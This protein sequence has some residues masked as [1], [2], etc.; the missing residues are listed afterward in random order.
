MKVGDMVSIKMM[1]RYMRSKC[2]G[3]EYIDA[4]K[5]PRCGEIV[6][7]LGNGQL[8]VL[9]GTKSYLLYDYEVE[10]KGAMAERLK[11]KDMLEAKLHEL[12]DADSTRIKELLDEGKWPYIIDGKETDLSKGLRKMLKEEADKAT[13]REILS[14]EYTPLTIDSITTDRSRALRQAL[15]KGG[16]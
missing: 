16:W 1:S 14:S 7:T 5:I 8:R 13:L 3:D 4:E 9:F 12:L 10:L 15:E 6:E 2:E 11:E